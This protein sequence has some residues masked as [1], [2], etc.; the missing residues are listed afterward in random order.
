MGIHSIVLPQSKVSG[1]GVI[2]SCKKDRGI[3]QVFLYSTNNYKQP[4]VCQ[5]LFLA[6][7]IQ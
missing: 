4:T 2:I 5:A 6:L 1:S 3:S 7:E